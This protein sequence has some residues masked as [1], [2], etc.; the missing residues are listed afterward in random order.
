MIHRPRHRVGGA[1]YHGDSAY[2]CQ[3][4]WLSRETARPTSLGDDV[5]TAPTDGRQANEAPDG[6]VKQNGRLI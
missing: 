1:S 6:R 5:H 2:G 3:R 4:A